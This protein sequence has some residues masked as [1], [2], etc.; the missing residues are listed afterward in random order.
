[1]SHRD[2]ARSECEWMLPCDRESHLTKH[3]CHGHRV[4]KRGHRARQI[5]VR[6][7]AIARQ[8]PCRQRHDVPRVAGI[9]K[10]HERVGRRAELQYQQPSPWP[11]HAGE[12]RG[13]AS[14]IID[15]SNAKGN[16]HDV[17]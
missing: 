13:G 2:R 17:A 16:R 14:R 11:Q 15:V 1:M 7:G 10:P 12:L 6:P 4:G 8:K 5:P 9:Q 3:V